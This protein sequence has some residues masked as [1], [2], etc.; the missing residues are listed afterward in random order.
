MEPQLN[1]TYKN[2]KNFILEAQGKKDIDHI[3][4]KYGLSS[5]E[6]TE[7]IN[8]IYCLI[9]DKDARISLTKLNKKIAKAYISTSENGD[10]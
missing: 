4:P 10:E 9:K 5:E 2:L 6:F 1:I 7:V 8:T 3:M